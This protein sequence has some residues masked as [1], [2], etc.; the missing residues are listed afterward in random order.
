G[1][2][3][4]PSPSPDEP[5]VDPLENVWPAYVRLELFQAEMFRDRRDT[6]A[7]NCSGKN[8]FVIAAAYPGGF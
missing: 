6:L 3:H 5:A 7:V 1:D 4:D 8:S 2:D